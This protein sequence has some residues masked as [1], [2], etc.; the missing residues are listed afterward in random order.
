M[1]DG[2]LWERES[3]GEAI[4]GEGSGFLARR[5]RELQDGFGAHAAERF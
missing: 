3:R 4:S 1:K 5:S 2:W